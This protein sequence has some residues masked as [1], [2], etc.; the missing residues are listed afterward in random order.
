MTSGPT[1][2]SKVHSRPRRVPSTAT[3]LGFRVDSRRTLP[4]CFPAALACQCSRNCEMKCRSTL[5]AVF[6]PD[7]PPYVSTMVRAIDNRG[8]FHAAWSCRT[9]RKSRRSPAPGCRD[10]NRSP[11]PRLWNPRALLSG[12]RPGVYLKGCRPSRPLRSLPNS[13]GPAAHEWDRRE[14]TM[15]LCG[16]QHAR[17]TCL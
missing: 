8:Q 10:Q 17:T 3:S 7:L 16:L 9:C 6:S 15:A 14:P 4:R 5:C 1:V 2:A 13:T 11:L 12:W